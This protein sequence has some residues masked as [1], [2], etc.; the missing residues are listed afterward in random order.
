MYT[1]E[2]MVIGQLLSYTKAIIS[3]L[4]ISI[5]ELALQKHRK[6]QNSACT[7]IPNQALTLCINRVRQY[8]EKTQGICFW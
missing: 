8:V 3:Y 6:L 5:M 4:S 2:Q 1:R 7:M